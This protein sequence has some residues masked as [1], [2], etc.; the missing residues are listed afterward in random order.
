MGYFLWLFGRERPTLNI[1]MKKQA[2]KTKN[3]PWSAFVS[4]KKILV[5]V[6]LAALVVAQLAFD[7]RVYWLSQNPPNPAI[8]ISMITDALN[9]LETPVPVEA[10]TGKPYIAANRLVW[11]AVPNSVTQLYYAD[12]GGTGDPELQITSRTTMSVGI[13]KLWNAAGTTSWHSTD[14]ARQNAIFAQVPSLQACA[15]GIQLF[16][17][18]QNGQATQW[19]A[20]GSKQ[21]A[22]GRTVYFYTESACREDLTF[23]LSYVKQ[24]QSY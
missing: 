8:V 3:T 19:Q 4:H 5:C 11:P 14:A 2:R 22:D 24:V 23:L 12:T 16:F 20:Q 18:P 9:G 10:A 21:L 7:A 1:S 17:H 15:R 13:S 6:A